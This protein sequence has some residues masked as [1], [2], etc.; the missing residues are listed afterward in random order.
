MKKQLF[1]KFL[2]ILLALMLVS[3]VFVACADE[4]P[5]EPPPTADTDD[6]TAVED[7]TE[8]TPAEERPLLT[9]DFFSRYTGGG[10]MQGGWFGN[11]IREKFDIELNFTFTDELFVARSAA[12][13]LGDIIGLSFVPMKDSIQAGLLMDITDFWPDLTNW[14]PF[15]RGI[16]NFK[17]YAETG[18][19]LFAMP[20]N[21]SLESTPQWGG[22]NPDRVHW[23]RWDFYRELGYPEMNDAHDLL[24]VLKQMQDNN[25]I[26]E[27]GQRVFGMSLFADWDGQ[28]MW[29][30]IMYGSLYGYIDKGFLMMRGDGS[31]VQEAVADDGIYKQA[32]Y[33]YFTA[34][35]M[36]LLDP[37]SAT[38]SADSKGDKFADG[39]VLWDFCGWWWWRFQTQERQDQGIGFAMAPVANQATYLRSNS[40]YG[41]FRNA[42]GLGVNAQEP[43]RLIEFLNWFA[44]PEYTEMEFTG[45]RGL[46]WDMVG[47]RPELL[48]DIRD[49]FTMPEEFNGLFLGGGLFADGTSRINIRVPNME[50][51]NP[52]TG[53]PFH[54]TFWESTTIDGRTALDEDWS[55]ATGYF[56]QRD[57]LEARNAYYAEPASP[58]IPPTPDS[59][60]E[61]MM[62]QIGDLIV[63]TSWRMVFARDEDEFHSLWADMK[64]QLDGL[65][66]QEVIEW[67]RNWVNELIA[68]FD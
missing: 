33:F 50:D 7:D 45:I 40:P 15:Q 16:D 36:G 28:L 47:G 22:T 19:R 30:A 49:D 20:G 63:Q 42:I 58:F 57:W 52:N 23:I 13:D 66:Y 18:D 29:N 53:E 3:S 54:H 62:S 34:N 48:V 51:I 14:H 67:N 35:Q 10:G 59:E 2:A 21:V 55:A 1:G 32:L 27:S 37:D 4:P 5:Q 61:L 68:T 41:T 64:S 39:A 44:S 65:G 46:T 38:Q 17:N 25:P 11:V 8:A 60:M 31:D 26:T 43:E 56:W 6:T 24:D 12:G 9:V